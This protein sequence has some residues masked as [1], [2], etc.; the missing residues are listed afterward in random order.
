MLGRIPRHDS[1]MPATGGVVIGRL[2]DVGDA[3][4]SG[5]ASVPG[6]GFLIKTVRRRSARYTVVAGS[7]D[8]GVLYG[9]QAG[10]AEVWRDAVAVSE[11]I[12]H[13]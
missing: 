3:L 10:Q 13:P 6:D 7:T 11:S 12:W 2:R 9:Y 8:R 4:P 1:A 5:E